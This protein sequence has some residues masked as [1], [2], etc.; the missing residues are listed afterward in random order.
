MTKKSPFEYIKTNFFD[1]K[2]REWPDVLMMSFFFFLV[3]SVFWVLKPMK[4]GLLVNLYQESPLAFLG[5]TFAGA[6]V[7]Q[8]AKVL[9]MI[10]VYGFVIL[11]T[12]LSRKLKRQQLNLFQCTLFSGL[13]IIFSFFIRDPGSYTAW[14]FY[15]LGDIFNSAMV[16]FF[17]A[18]S[19]DLFTSEQAKRT[20][21]LVGL[22]GIIGGIVGSSIVVGLVG[23]VGRSTLLIACIAP[24]IIIAGIGYIVNQRTESESKELQKPCADGRQCNVMFEG[25]RIVTRSKYLLAIVG[26]LGLYEIVSNIVDFQLSATIAA[27]ISG[28]V[29]K[30]AYF[31]IVGQV[32]SIISLVI[33]LFFTSYVMKRF[34]VGVAL[35]FL[36]VAI[37]FGSIGFLFS[38]ILIFATIMSVSDNS[39]NY[40][41]NQSAKEALYTPTIRDVKYKAK[42]FIDMFVQRFAKVLAVILNLAVAA[43]VGLENVQWL[44][45]ATLLIMVIWIM[46]VLYAGREFNK[47]TEYETPSSPI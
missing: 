13:F 15:V 34:G 43:W 8:L 2:R 22:G 24:M 46:L 3:I 30:D 41:I 16:T 36:P 31:G 12:F 9:N 39:L 10:V 28:D 47:K 26:I 4:R 37:T 19:N 32:T 14:S 7:E 44:T 21:G 40:S 25:A 42:A 27:S 11:F 45:V 6:E 17:W 23:D 20:Y 35:L 18:F 5:T 33:Q 29:E 1:V 38:P